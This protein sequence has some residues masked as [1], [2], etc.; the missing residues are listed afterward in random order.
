MKTSDSR[1]NTSCII[2]QQQLLGA[3]I[4]QTL[5]KMQELVSFVDKKRRESGN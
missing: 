3:D 4:W 2:R 1:D 5:E